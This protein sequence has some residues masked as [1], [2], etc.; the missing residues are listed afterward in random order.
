MEYNIENTLLTDRE[1]EVVKQKA[2]D[3]LIGILT[4][5]VNESSHTFYGDFRF[6]TFT[7]NI[8]SI[9]NEITGA[10]ELLKNLE[11]MSYNELRKLGSKYKIKKDPKLK[12][13]KVLLLNEVEKAITLKINDLRNTSNE[14]ANAYTK[15]YK[16]T[17]EYFINDKIS[18]LESAITTEHNLDNLNKYRYLRD[19]FKVLSNNLK[20]I[21]SWIDEL[22]YPAT[23][24]GDYE[25]ELNECNQ[26][27]KEYQDK[28]VRSSD[29][30]EVM[31][32]TN[33]L[34]QE[35]EKKHELKKDIKIQKQNILD[36]YNKG[37]IEINFVNMRN[38]F[39]KSMLNI[40]SN[41]KEAFENGI[42]DKTDFIDIDSNGK[43]IDKC[44]RAFH[45]FF[46]EIIEKEFE[47]RNY[48]EENEIVLE[49]DSRE[50]TSKF[51]NLVN[52]R[53]VSFTNENSSVNTSGENSK[54]SSEEVN[55]V[56]NDNKEI[57]NNSLNNENVIS[58]DV[59]PIGKDGI[60]ES[61]EITNNEETIKDQSEHELNNE[62][63]EQVVEEPA[64]PE[65]ENS[66]SSLEQSTINL[67][68][69]FASQIEAEQSRNNSTDNQND[70]TILGMSTIPD[71][72][73]KETNSKEDDFGPDETKNDDAL[74]EQFNIVQN[75]PTMPGIPFVPNNENN[76]EE[77][78]LEG[79][80]QQNDEENYT[81]R[82]VLI[83]FCN[84]T[85]D[86]IELKVID[87]KDNTIDKISQQKTKIKNALIDSKEKIFTKFRDIYINDQKKYE[88]IKHHFMHENIFIRAQA[89]LEEI[90]KNII[91][92]YNRNHGGRNL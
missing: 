83:A 43:E 9:Q 44:S 3:K 12:L 48:L 20:D 68:Q 63:S 86:A 60:S 34:K 11:G 14:Y 79:V 29:Y 52:N 2:D 89:K 1:V 7:N 70:A 53:T 45:S 30:N 59:T 4:S 92:E 91:N 64:V 8:L 73:S 66:K 31:E 18:K 25:D 33:L 62:Q 10:E 36:V 51:F 37:N 35:N 16:N 74:K 75:D 88:K 65:S 49:N 82:D 5:L 38:E 22:S 87:I 58:N 24:L 84:N 67:S 69:S 19:N 21:H 23:L 27:I 39:L 55:Y 40:T 72:V 50:R 41:C 26:K 77:Q 32:L 6:N 13:D 42:L 76:S 71:Y 78:T 80:E 46:Y 54:S 81:L 28:I 56:D 61:I 17:F 15:N 47:F 57:T 85:G 90:K